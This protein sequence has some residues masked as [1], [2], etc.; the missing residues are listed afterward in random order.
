LC[1]STPAHS[2][3]DRGALFRRKAASVAALR[4]GSSERAPFA[5]YAE[6]MEIIASM[7]CFGVVFA[8]RGATIVPFEKCA[9]MRAVPMLGLIIFA[10]CNDNPLQNANG[11]NFLNRNFGDGPKSRGV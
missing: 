5:K 2:P 3:K 11:W 10:F 7:K 1:I 9:N 8:Q 4:T 6:L